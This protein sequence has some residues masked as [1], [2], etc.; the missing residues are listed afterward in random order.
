MVKNFGVYKIRC[1]ITNEI[2]IGS[3]T[4]PFNKRWSVHRA[5]LKKGNHRNH[6][7]QDLYNKS[8]AACFEYT[9][10]EVVKDE[11]SV[12][13]REQYYMDLLSPELN[14]FKYAGSSRGRVI[15]EQHKKKIKNSNKGRKLTHV[16]ELK[17]KPTQ[18]K[19][20]DRAWN[21]G[22]IMPEKVRLNISNAKKGIPNKKLSKKVEYNGIIYDSIAQ[23]EKLTGVPKSTICR[24]SK[25]GKE[26][27]YV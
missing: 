3:T 10:I 25:I 7:L 6:L 8:G 13:D 5:H 27:K 14:I 16:H 17:S 22:L 9:I 24:K 26:F 2:Y 12:L 15:S 21:L 19:K 18:F 23:A 1:I 4:T 20:G 11:R